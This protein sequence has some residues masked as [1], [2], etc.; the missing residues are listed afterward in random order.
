MFVTWHCRHG[1]SARKPRSDAV[2]P[3]LLVP[4]VVPGPNLVFHTGYSQLLKLKAVR[5]QY[6]QVGMYSFPLDF[7]KRF[8]FNIFSENIA[9]ALWS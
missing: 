9:S 4:S 2:C 3:V 7:L 5:L 1:G 8:I 6:Q